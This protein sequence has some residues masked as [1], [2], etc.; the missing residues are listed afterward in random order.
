MRSLILLAVIFLTG[1]SVDNIPFSNLSSGFSYMIDNFV[2]ETKTPFQTL[3]PVT[4][5]N[6]IM[7]VALDI[8]LVSVNSFDEIGGYLEISGYLDLKWTFYAANPSKDDVF[9]LYSSGSIWKPP[10]LLLNSVKSPS[11]IGDSTSKIRCNLKSLD[12]EWKPWVILQ[13]A[14]TPD[15]R[16]YPFDTQ[17]CSYKIAAWGHLESE[18]TLTP[19]RSDWNK[20]LFEDNEE[21]TIQSTKSVA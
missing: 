11:E 3:I 10:L 6:I 7:D 19:A 8:N 16:F 15:V 12:C 18:L 5:T 14:C 13:G 1:E 2:D 4:Y 20:E 9:V 17:T 21:W